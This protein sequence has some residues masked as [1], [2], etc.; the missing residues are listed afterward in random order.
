MLRANVGT[1]S[2]IAGKL[3]KWWQWLVEARDALR[4][5][6]QCRVWC[7]VLKLTTRISMF[8]PMQPLA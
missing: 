8:S 3:G 4:I 2:M 5:I 6:S 7:R 1:I